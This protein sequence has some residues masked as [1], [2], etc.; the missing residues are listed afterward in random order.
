MY[1][2]T[3]TILWCTV[4]IRFQCYGVLVFVSVLAAIVNNVHYKEFL[5]R[6]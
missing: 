2:L 3:Y 1:E 5:L 6:P 4:S